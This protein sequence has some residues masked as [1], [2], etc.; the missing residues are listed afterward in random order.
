MGSCADGLVGWGLM[1]TAG[2]QGCLAAAAGPEIPEGQGGACWHLVSAKRVRR[3]E[4]SISSGTGMEQR[5]PGVRVCAHAG[6][7]GVEGCMLDNPAL[8][9]LVLRLVNGKQPFRINVFQMR[10][11]NVVC[12]IGSICLSVH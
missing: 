2:S 3:L 12:L 8:S 10:P 6:D 1:G 9:A 7:G 11:L 5:G 4:C